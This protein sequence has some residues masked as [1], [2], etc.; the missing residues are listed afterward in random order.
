MNAMVVFNCVTF[1]FRC[2]K[3]TMGRCWYLPRRLITNTFQNYELAIVL[4]F[5][6]M[7]LA[8]KF[9]KQ[10]QI[11]SFPKEKIRTVRESCQVFTK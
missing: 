11:E 2:F 6:F 10:K 8:L 1:N 5:F 4:P 3:I 9:I 7:S